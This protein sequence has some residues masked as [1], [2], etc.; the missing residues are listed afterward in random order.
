MLVMFI[1][2]EF[3]KTAVGGYG[4][5]F[6]HEAFTGPHS[7]DSLV[8]NLF[9]VHSLGLYDHLTWNS[10][11][12]SDSVQFW[13]YAVFASVVVLGP[14]RTVVISIIGGIGAG[15][16]IGALS[17]HVPV[18][19][20][21]YDYGGLRC[22]LGLGVG[23]LTYQIYRKRH[24]AVSM[25]RPWGSP[26]SA[27]EV[28]TLVALFGFIYTAGTGYLTLA[29][30]LIFAVVIYVFAHEQGIASRLLQSRPL[31]QLGRWSYA[32]YLTHLMVITGILELCH[33]V[34]RAAHVTLLQETSN[35]PPGA[36]VLQ[37]PHSEY[38]MDAVTF[39]YVAIVIA[40]AAI[41]HR[42]VEV[43]CR[44]WLNRF[45]QGRVHQPTM[46]TQPAA[47]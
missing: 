46:R 30:P 25:E 26:R 5:H 31:Q 20:I 16:V 10:P 14:R 43:P 24:A 2:L 4:M 27:P 13:G 11:S 32:I 9:L 6:R 7:I 17:K 39:A 12:W 19:D 28:L 41:M 44:D 34:E 42:L 47:P 45:I 1:G 8:A 36:L 33:L 35:T 15:V 22:L 21:T 37:L 18:D 29:S 23:H 38:L 3:V 40:F